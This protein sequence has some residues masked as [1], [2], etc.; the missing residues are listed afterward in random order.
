M[1]CIVYSLNYIRY[2]SAVASPGGQGEHSVQTRKICKGCGRA[3]AS[4]YSEPKEQ[5][6]NQIFVNFLKIILKFSKTFKF[7]LKYFKI[8][9]KIFE[10]S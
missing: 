5:R 9:N 3:R 7:F 1:T 6:K 10:I 8:V 4:A 2:K